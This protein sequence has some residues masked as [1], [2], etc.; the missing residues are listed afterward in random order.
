M[1]AETLRAKIVTGLHQ[2]Q[3]YCGDGYYPLLPIIVLDG[4]KLLKRRPRKSHG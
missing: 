3:I 2:I 4:S 1:R